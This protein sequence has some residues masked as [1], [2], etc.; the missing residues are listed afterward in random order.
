MAEFSIPRNKRGIFIAITETVILYGVRI[1]ELA[2]V[3]L[4]PSPSFH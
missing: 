4:V 1:R 2:I 3:S